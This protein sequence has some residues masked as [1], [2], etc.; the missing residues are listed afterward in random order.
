M[1]IESAFPILDP[2]DADAEEPPTILITGAAGNIG[3]KLRDAWADRFE[4]I[5]IDR[6]ADP[7]DPD[8]IIA[9][10]AEPIDD[11]MDLFDEADVV[12]HLA[13]NPNEFATWAE[14]V[15][16][17]IDMMVNV[18]H[19]SVRAGVG[20]FIFASSN[21]VMGGYR[22]GVDR[23]ITVEL[24]PKPGNPYG[25]TKL[26]GERLGRSLAKMVDLAFIALRIGWV[27]KG[28]NRPEDLPDDWARSIWLSNGDLVRLVTSAV[29]AELVEG[30]FVVVNG[31][32]N[33]RGTRWD[34]APARARLGFEPL[35][36]AWTDR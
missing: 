24:P 23:P 25:A 1:S 29:E 7:D 2:A 13:A 35:D 12:V 9:D 32:S 22:E 34:L 18:L 10:L 5:A 8:L 14:L 19:A 26:M 36:D 30:E 4:L 28:A 21:H 33:N 15:G 20:R 6:V 31:V 17:N 16:P 27:L 3:R 11:W